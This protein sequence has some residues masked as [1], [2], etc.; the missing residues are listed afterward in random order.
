[1]IVVILFVLC[2]KTTFMFF[3]DS[4]NVITLLKD[5]CITINPQQTPVENSYR[6]HNNTGEVNWKHIFREANK[7]VDD[8][9]KHCLSLDNGVK[10]FKFS[11]P[12]FISNVSLV[13]VAGVAFP[14]S[15]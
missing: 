11:P 3:I 4:I 1:M 13:D 14:I 5:G 10:V 9:V 7:V 2:S 12:S 15:F 6:I 8:L